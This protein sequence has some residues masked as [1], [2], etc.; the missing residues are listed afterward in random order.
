MIDA[1]KTKMHSAQYKLKWKIP[2]TVCKAYGVQQHCKKRRRIQY[3]S[4][5]CCE[6]IE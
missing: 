5:Y 3:Y 4:I 2:N 1:K 6:L